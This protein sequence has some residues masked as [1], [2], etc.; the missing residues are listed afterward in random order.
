MVDG[1]GYNGVSMEEISAAGGCPRGSIY[2]LKDGVVTRGILFDA[3]RLPGKATAQGWLEPGTAIHRE[4]LETLERIQRVRVSP[5]DVIL[6]YTGRWKRRAALGPWPNS[7]GFA[8]Y[9]VDVAYF[10][11]ERGV[12]FIGSDGPNDV[13]PSGLPQGVGL[14]QLA[15]VAM[16]VSIFD[17]LDFERAAEEARRMNR[18]EFLFMAAPLR[19]EKGMG[20]PLNPLAVF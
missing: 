3:T 18:Y 12:S 15:L 13:S 6:L 7:T 8:G 4:D 1:K 14:H 11:K 10:L 16:G 17:N 2:A 9:H 19:I 5:G 20:S